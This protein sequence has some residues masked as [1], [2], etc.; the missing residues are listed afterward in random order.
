MKPE[1]NERELLSGVEFGF[2]CIG[3]C[4]DQSEDEGDRRDGVEDEGL[5]DDREDASREWG[6]LLG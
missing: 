3:L 1:E 5:G 4:A 6:V 2:G